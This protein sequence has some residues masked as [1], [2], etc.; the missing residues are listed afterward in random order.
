MSYY[1][2]NELSNIGF[3]HIG[4]N[5]LLS[6]KVSIYG[7]EHIRL[8]NNIRID[9]FCIL[10]AGEGGISIGN[11]IHIACY[12]SI[13]G[14]AAITL[15]DYCNISARVSIYSSN[16]D[17][18]G[19]YLT[20]P[21]VPNKYTNVTHCS[22]YIGKHVIIGCGSVILSGTNIANGCAIGALSLV[23][24]SLPEWGIYVGQPVKYIK[25]RNKKLLLLEKKL[26]QDIFLAKRSK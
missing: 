17:Y 12:S 19:E 7:A 25:A 2:E 20:N 21:M 16:D 1:T 15:S 8:G 3:A 14:A 4:T 26:S 6:R 11:Y 9:D 24:K 22:V 5:V 23:N 13:I 18:S 10:S